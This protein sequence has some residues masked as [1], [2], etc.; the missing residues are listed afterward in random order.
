MAEQQIVEMIEKLEKLEI[1]GFSTNKK[2]DIVFGPRVTT[3]SGKSFIGKSA[4]VRALKWVILNKP[5]GDKFI[6]W[7]AIKAA[8]RLT[9]DKGKQITRKKGKGINTYKYSESKNLFKAFGNDVPPIISKALNISPINFQRQHAAPFWFCETAGEVSR[10]LNSIVNLEVIDTTLSNLSSKIRKTK[11][12]IDISQER[13]TNLAK[14]KKE[15]SYVNN[16]NQELLNIETLQKQIQDKVLKCSSLQNSIDKVVKYTKQKEGTRDRRRAGKLA[17]SKGKTYYTLV[18]QIEELE[19]LIINIKNTKELKCQTKKEL[20][21]SKKE[22][23]K[24]VGESCPLC[25]SPMKK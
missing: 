23:E 6:N 12:A 19:N 10:Q 15:L 21:S 17:I 24:I 4:F 25:G 18:T 8:V 2:L 9:F 1:R 16:M 22:L 11:T 5:T 13:L 3:I 14:G 20:I 7:D